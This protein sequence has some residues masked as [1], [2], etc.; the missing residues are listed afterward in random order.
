MPTSCAA[1]AS[2][3]ARSSSELWRVFGSP[4]T[5][6]SSDAPTDAASA[7]ADPPPGVGSDEENA[8]KRSR[9]DLSSRA[10]DNLSF[11]DHV[12]DG[13]DAD[14]DQID[15][16]SV[17]RHRIHLLSHFQAP[18]AVVAIERVRRVDRR[19]DERFFERET[20]AEAGERHGERHR[21]RE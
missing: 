19:G 5:I 7:L 21:R 14:T 1:A 8:F 17:D 13:L 4:A 2:S 16:R 15:R 12:T 9:T 20:H 18:D 11:L 6:S 3:A 10:N